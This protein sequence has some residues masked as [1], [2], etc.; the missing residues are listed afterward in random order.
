MATAPPIQHPELVRPLP[1]AENV[2]PGVDLPRWHL[3]PTTVQARLQTLRE[4]GVLP[5]RIVGRRLLW[6]EA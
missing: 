4:V 2:V 1:G 3:H 5:P 6:G